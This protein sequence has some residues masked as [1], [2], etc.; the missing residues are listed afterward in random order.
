MTE[1]LKLILELMDEQL[2]INSLKKIKALFEKNMDQKYVECIYETEDIL[3]PAQ[4]VQK[5]KTVMV[6]YKNFENIMNQTQEDMQ[7]IIKT[8][9]DKD[10]K[11]LRLITA[12]RIFLHE[13]HHSKQIYNVIDLKDDIETEIIKGLLNIDK[14]NLEDEQVK[15][16]IDFKMMPFIRLMNG[17]AIFNPI[18]R[19]AEI[20]SFKQVHKLLEQVKEL[21][22]NV[23]DYTYMSILGNTKDG[24]G[25]HEP[26]E[27]LGDDKET[28]Y[29]K[30]LDILDYFGIN[31]RYPYNKINYNDAIT[32][33]KEK[34]SEQE[35]YE[36]GLEVSQETKDNL[37]DNIQKVYKKYN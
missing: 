20:E 7:Y 11:F 23:Y 35:R 12:Y 33:I 1:D 5:Y 13:Y 3:P 4:F 21:Y 36:L 15:D 6:N 37:F 14:E 16:I 24:Y 27:C 26:V 22:P 18:E 17:N 8:S 29:E 2:D 25:K 28:P 10:I 31:Y 19:K 9:T 34:T 32:E 30:T